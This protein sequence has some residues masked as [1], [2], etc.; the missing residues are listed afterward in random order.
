V[1]GDDGSIDGHAVLWVDNHGMIVDPTIMRLQRLYS[2][3]PDPA[4]ST[5]IIL[6]VHRRELVLGP[7]SGVCPACRRSPLE[8]AWIPEPQWAQAITPIAGT[9]LNVALRYGALALVHAAL[10]LILG[11]HGIRDDLPGPELASRYPQ[12]GALVDG[13]THLPVLPD[14][15]PAALLYLCSITGTASSH[16]AA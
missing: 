16:A 11:L 5:P 7:V 12:L 1:L 4:L 8:I 2:V 14:E 3:A 15:P 6:P 13:R 9:S 10:E